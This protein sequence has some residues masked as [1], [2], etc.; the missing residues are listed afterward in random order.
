MNT[1][2]LLVLALEFSLLARRVEELTRASY[3]SKHAQASGN[4]EPKVPQEIGPSHALY[5]LAE[6]PHFPTSVPPLKA[7]ASSQRVSRTICDAP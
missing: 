4:K 7:P 1:V 6:S 3:R 2:F 5:I